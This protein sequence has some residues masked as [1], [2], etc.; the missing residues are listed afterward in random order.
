M[1]SFKAWCTSSATALKLNFEWGAT[2]AAV[3]RSPCEFMWFWRVSCLEAPDLPSCCSAGVW[4]RA[5]GN[6]WPHCWSLT[7]ECVV[8][9]LLLPLWGQRREP[10]CC[11]MGGKCHLG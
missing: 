1:Y 4:G 6:R 8:L 7:S 10:V 11:G 2:P 5:E 3:S 9:H